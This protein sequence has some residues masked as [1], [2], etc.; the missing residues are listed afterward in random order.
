MYGVPFLRDPESHFW[1]R[2]KT[3]RRDA[4]AGPVATNRLLMATNDLSRILR[5]D[6]P[7]QLCSEECVADDSAGAR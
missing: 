4:S 6:W 3:P 2:K 1:A 7:H 5:N